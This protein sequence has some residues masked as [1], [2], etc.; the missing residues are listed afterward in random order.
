MQQR[1]ERAPS[2]RHRAP[3][4]RRGDAGG[5]L[6]VLGRGLAAE[7]L[8]A[9]HDGRPDLAQLLAVEAYRKEPSVYS[10]GSLL[11]AV[12][13]QPALESELHG[14]S[15]GPDTVAIS[16]DG[17]FV[18]AQ[19]GNEI[20]LWDRRSGQLVGRPTDRPRRG[21]SRVCRSRPTVAVGRV[22]PVG[23]IQ[24]V[25][26]APRHLGRHREAV[27][28]GGCRPGRSPRPVP[29]RAPSPA[30]TLR[31]CSRSSTSKTVSVSARSTRGR[32]ARSS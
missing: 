21:E 20:R 25:A 16:A 17:A 22:R 10:R 28:S 26:A 15:A 31:E 27:C 24:P 3:R 19:S 32:P 7:S 8:N 5:D 9:L 13:N 11:Q 29:K 4:G 30:S 12:V 18:A 6:S 23:R 1:G 2:G 14:L